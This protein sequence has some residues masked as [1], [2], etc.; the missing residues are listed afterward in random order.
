[1]MIL[2][3]LLVQQLGAASVCPKKE[4]ISIFGIRGRTATHLCP[5]SCEVRACAGSSGML[6]HCF[7]AVKH[8]DVVHAA[9]QSAR[10]GL[11]V[12]QKDFFFFGTRGRTATHLSPENCE[13]SQGLCGLIRHGVSLL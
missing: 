1:M 8:V 13:V 2:C 11:C 4:D 5:E 9:R 3:M 12:F 6:S 10:R 7:E